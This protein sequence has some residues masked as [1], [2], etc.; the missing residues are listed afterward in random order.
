MLE[1]LVI[2][3]RLKLA[4]SMGFLSQYY[5]NLGKFYCNLIQRVLRYIAGILDLRL[6]FRKDSE[7]NIVG[8]LDSDYA[9][10]IDR[11]KSTEAYVFM[12]ADRLIS[13]SSKL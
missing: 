1:W 4:Y 6:M 10:L 8:Y 2:Y 11:K 13:H 7:D 12:F 3:I 5:S 9:R